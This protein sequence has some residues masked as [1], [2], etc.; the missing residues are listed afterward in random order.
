MEMV[1]FT[2]KFGQKSK[3]SAELREVHYS[4][5]FQ[6]ESGKVIELKRTTQVHAPFLAESYSAAWLMSHILRDFMTE[7]SQA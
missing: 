7:V 1:E 5:Q 2:V 4:A 3:R 6:T